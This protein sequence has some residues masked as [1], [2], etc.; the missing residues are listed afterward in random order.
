MDKFVFVLYAGLK[1]GFKTA[2]L[3]LLIIVPVF[4]ITTILRHSFVLDYLSDI[5]SPI[6]S[7][8]NLEGESLVPVVA[9]V[10]GDEYSVVAAFKSFNFSSF[11]ITTVSMII[12]CFH[13][14]PVETGVSKLIGFSMLKVFLF[15][16]CLAIFSGVLTGFSAGLFLGV[17]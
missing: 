14:I 15:R 12:L 6:M 9:G 2:G 16:F 3:L 8:F 7:I 5:L 1:K 17:N 10:F 11:T 13:S 4:G